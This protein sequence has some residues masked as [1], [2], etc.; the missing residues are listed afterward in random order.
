MRLLTFGL[1]LI[2]FWAHFILVSFLIVNDDRRV[3]FCAIVGY[4][5][6]TAWWAPVLVRMLI[7]LL[8]E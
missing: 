8:T 5:A 2:D 3:S 6:L 7:Q 1:V 4:L